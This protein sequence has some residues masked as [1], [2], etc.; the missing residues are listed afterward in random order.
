MSDRHRTRKQRMI[1]SEQQLNVPMN[2][3]LEVIDYAEMDPGMSILTYIYRNQYA[4]MNATHTRYAIWVNDQPLT[5]GT[6]WSDFE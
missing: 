2:S 5:S 3:A 4:G 1:D 6:L